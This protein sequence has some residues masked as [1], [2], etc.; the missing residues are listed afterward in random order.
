MIT[1][2]LDVRV[3]YAETD[4]MGFVYHGNY[5]TWFEAARIQMLDDMGIPYK[6]IE[7]EGA[8]LPVLTAHADYRMPATFDDRLKIHTTITEKPRL[9][10][11]ID[12][13]V[14]RADEELATG[15]TL[16]AFIDNEGRPTRPPKAFTVAVGRYF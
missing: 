7:A 5:F 14:T 6:T 11:R 4:Q 16:H 15:Y 13:R 12:Y 10:I 8:F 2:V 9:R 3:R 1:S